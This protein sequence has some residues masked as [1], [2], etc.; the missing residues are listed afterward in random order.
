MKRLLACLVGAAL[1]SL[2]LAAHAQPV[3]PPETTANC[4]F[5][6]SLPTLISGQMG[7]VQCDSTGH[8][9]VAASVSASITGFQPSVSGTFSAPLS[10]SNVSASVTLPTGAVVIVTNTGAT[11]A[12][13]AL[14][15]SATTA[16]QYIGPAGGWFAYTVGS[17]TQ[18]SCLTASSTTTVNIQGGTGLATGVGGAGS[19]TIS[20]TINTNQTQLNSVALGSPSN[21]GTSPGAVAVPGVNASVT[22]SALPTGAATSALQSTGNTSLASILTA[23]GS[24]FQAGGSI[25]NTT[26]IATQATG[27]NLH[28]VCDSGCSGSGGTAS[29]FGSAF[30]TNGT[31]IGLTNGTNM[32]A[33]SATSNYGTAPSAIAVPAV[34]AYVTNSNTNGQAAPANSS[35]V[36]LSHTATASV[37]ISIST[38]TTTQLVALSGSTKIYVT[39]WDVIAAG[40]GNIQ[41]EYGTGTACATGTTALTGNYNLTAQVGLT[42]GSGDA[43]VLIVP[44]GN[45]LCALTSAAVG[46][47]GSLAYS[48]F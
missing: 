37:P 3:V 28:I 46:I 21:Y 42:K 9:L 48:Q 41:L 27:S 35:P 22:A 8:L 2:G 1:M 15:A 6:S 33:W 12:Y 10:V 24:P 47:A 29:A 7:R 5:N 38:A 45:A 16:S 34:N 20:G 19:A 17:A 4:A 14:G 26:F 31:A 36:V 44:A 13:C 32:V 39:A 43:P 25:G 40:T 18:L 11:A 30:P 23:L